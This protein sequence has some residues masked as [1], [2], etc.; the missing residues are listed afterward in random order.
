[1]SATGANIVADMKQYPE[2]IG[3]VGTVLDV[4]IFHLP[5]LVASSLMRAFA[6]DTLK[7]RLASRRF[8]MEK[9]DRRDATDRLRKTDFAN[10]LA[11]GVTGLRSRKKLG[12]KSIEAFEKLA[13]IAEKNDSELNAAIGS[14]L[15]YAGLATDFKVEQNF[16]SGLSRR[17]DLLLDTGAGPVR[18]EVMWRRKTGRAEVANYT[19]GKVANYARAIGFIK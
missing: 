1:M 10:V 15:V 19:L 7:T 18:V 4:K 12:S 8:Q 17:T 16:G 11:G 9:P 6:S 3:I 2:K 14:A 13:S 5:V